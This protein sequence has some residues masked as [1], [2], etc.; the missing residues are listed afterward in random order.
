MSW[1]ERRSSSA[2][3][4]NRRLAAVS[5][6]WLDQAAVE[7]VAF[8]CLRPASKHNAHRPDA[9]RGSA[10]GIGVSATGANLSGPR[11]SCRGVGVSK[12]SS[13]N[14]SKKLSILNRSL[15]GV[16]LVK[17][18]DELVGSSVTVSVW[19]STGPLRDSAMTSVVHVP[20]CV[21]KV[22]PKTSCSRVPLSRTDP[23]GVL[24]RVRQCSDKRCVCREVLTTSV[25]GRNDRR[26]ERDS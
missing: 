17:P 16:M 6:N 12:V 1:G 13:T 18:V 2:W 14:T 22:R 15:T 4:V 20:V 21:L 3:V 10:V 11:V 26:S 5:S 8:R 25:E 24:P 19:P 7:A 9:K 23:S